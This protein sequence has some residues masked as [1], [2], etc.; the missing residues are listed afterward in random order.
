MGRPSVRLKVLAWRT[1]ISQFQVSC[2]IFKGEGSRAGKRSRTLIEFGGS[3]IFLAVFKDFVSQC[4]L[5]VLGVRPV[6]RNF[7][8]VSSQLGLHCG[9]LKWLQGSVFTTRGH[10]WAQCQPELPLKA[11]LLVLHSSPRLRSPPLVQRLSG[12]CWVSTV[13]QNN[14]YTHLEKKKQNLHIYSFCTTIHFDSSF[15]VWSSYDKTVYCCTI[16]SQQRVLPS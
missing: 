14:V 6:F 3:N 12:K 10:S 1:C 11:H 16:F 2:S 5:G 13:N 7:M 9:H 8:E 15:E 4:F